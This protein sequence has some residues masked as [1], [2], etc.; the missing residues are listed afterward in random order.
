M[1]SAIINRNPDGVKRE[2]SPA[3]I[4]RI[5]HKY[6]VPYDSRIMDILPEIENRRAYRGMDPKPISEESV[7]RILEAATLAPSCKNN[8]A[9][10]FV[11]V[12]DSA[13]LGEIKKHF[14]P[15]NYW[16]KL[17]PLIVA[18]CV[19]P[20]DDCQQS[21][22]R[23]YGLF[24]IGLATQNLILQAV[25]EG[26]HAH[27]IAGFEPGAVKELLS[28]PETTVLVALIIIA[29]PGDTDHLNEKHKLSEASARRR[30]PMS[31]VIAYNRFSRRWGD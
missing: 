26:Y 10:R 18:A 7:D 23:E 16:A 27:P 5:E 11:V 4:G 28:V 13:Q 20:T 1:R 9:W 31:D 25:R 17:A 29:F 24:D 3:C 6:I 8:Q 30:K 2:G 14:T 21:F 22:G 15:A 19:D 12:S